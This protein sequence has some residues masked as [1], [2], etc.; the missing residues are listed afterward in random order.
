MQRLESGLWG[1]WARGKRLRIAARGWI[2]FLGIEISARRAAVAAKTLVSIGNMTAMALGTL[3][4]QYLRRGCR[5]GRTR[6]R[7]LESLGQLR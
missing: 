1:L 3:F 6:G 7:L 4:S 2:L 5:K